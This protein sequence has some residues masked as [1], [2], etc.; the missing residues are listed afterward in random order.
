M[1]AFK[2]SQGQLRQT[3]LLRTDAGMKRCCVA[4][5]WRNPRFVGE[6]N[7]SPQMEGLNK[8]ANE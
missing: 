4:E 6:L 2:E 7:M 8:S 5:V 1:R 3:Q